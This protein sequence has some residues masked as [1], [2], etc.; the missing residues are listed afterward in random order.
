M[1]KVHPT[2]HDYIPAAGRDWT[3]PFYDTMTRLAGVRALHRRLVAG[4]DLASGQRVL[5][6]GCGTG[7]LSTAVKRAEPG[8]ELTAIDPD[9]LA[10][11]RA[12]RKSSTIDFRIG[13]AQELPFAD[14]TVDRAFS[15]L[16]LHHLDPE[17]VKSALAELFRVC[18]PGG[19]VHVVDFIEVRGLFARMGHH[20]FP[21]VDQLSQ[22]M[23]DAGFASVEV[24]TEHR[25][26]VGEFAYVRATRATGPTDSE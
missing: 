15:S 13:Y 24:E 21:G 14:E 16:M 25:R 2:A 5:E 9:P 8:V 22:L 7:N 3:L 10:L 19:S 23:T 12:R 20:H 4:A 1:T 18:K 17:S 6:I 26:L 11:D